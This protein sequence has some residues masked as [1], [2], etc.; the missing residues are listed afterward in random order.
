MGRGGGRVVSLGSARAGA[1]RAR[2]AAAPPAPAALK[3]RGAVHRAAQAGWVADVEPAR[4][5]LERWMCRA[6]G[7]VFPAGTPLALVYLPMPWEGPRAPCLVLAEE[8]LA[9]IR[10]APAVGYA[11]ADRVE[12]L[13]SRFPTAGA[14]LLVTIGGRLHGLA[15]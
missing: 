9:R 5:L 15:A 14:I 6:G 13:A 2:F 8:A 4:W 12:R 11:L 1:G 10:D 7:R 3:L